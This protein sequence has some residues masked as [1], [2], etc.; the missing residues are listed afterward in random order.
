MNEKLYN[1]I[2]SRRSVRKYDHGDLDAATMEGVVSFTASI[3]PLF[4]E[5]RTELR[6][7]RSEDVRGMFKVETPHYLAIYSENRPGHEANA[8][9]MLQQVDLH[10]SSIGLGS[11]WQGGPRPVRGKRQL[12]GLDFVVMLA[13]GRAQEP[14]HRERSA[15]KRKA[16]SQ[17]TDLTEHFDVLEA[18]RIA[19]SGTNNQS[20]YF[21]GDDDIIHA[22]AARSAVTDSMNR[23]NVGIALAHMW[24]AVEH[25]GGRATFA[26]EEEGKKGT[27]RGYAYVA[28]MRIGHQGPA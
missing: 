14:V 7:L 21:S 26:L 22:Y 9:F 17:I 8:G 15:F 3:R 27:P 23:I 13:F 20:W 18:A 11:C 2:F 1:A 10:L 19:P 6:F 16:L 12:S 4:P 24:L 5:V 28:S 25:D